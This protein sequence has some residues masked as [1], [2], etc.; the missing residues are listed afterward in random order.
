[1][2]ID[3]PNNTVE[4]TDKQDAGNSPDTTI[5]PQVQDHKSHKKTI[6]N[7]KQNI[8]EPKNAQQDQTTENFEEEEQSEL[9]TAAINVDM[10]NGQ[11]LYTIQLNGISI[12]IAAITI[13]TSEG[14]RHLQSAIT[15]LPHSSSSS[16]SKLSD[17]PST[18]PDLIPSLSSHD[19]A[20]QSEHSSPV[21]CECSISLYHNYPNKGPSTLIK[22]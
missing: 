7:E 16:L 15:S 5:L 13:P 12:P 6:F 17:Q 3:I 18:K 10:I 2:V 9:P 4:L 11:P 21:D 19:E 8:E 1:M 14:P 22:I 20:I